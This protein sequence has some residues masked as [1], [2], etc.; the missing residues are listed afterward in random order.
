[1]TSEA[2]YVNYSVSN[3]IRGLDDF[4]IKDS[5]LL[6]AEWM[7]QMYRDLNNLGIR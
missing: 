7:N 6:F 1:M 5:T 2:N 4:V 3:E